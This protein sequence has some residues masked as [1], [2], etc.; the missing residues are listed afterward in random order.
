MWR[1]KNL[2][3]LLVGMPNDAAVV[4]DMSWVPQT[5]FQKNVKQT[6][7]DKCCVHLFI[8]QQPRGRKKDE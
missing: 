7:R 2:C 4:G 6:Q 5:S 3:V 8:A 1:N